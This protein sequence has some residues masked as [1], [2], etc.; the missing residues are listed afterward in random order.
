MCVRVVGA[1]LC[2]NH[3]PWTNFCLKHAG[4]N[5]SEATKGAGR[6]WL[7]SDSEPGRPAGPMADRP[8]P[9]PN[10]GAPRSLTRSLD[11]VHR[12][13]WL[14]AQLRRGRP[15]GP[16][17]GRSAP[18]GGRSPPAFA[19]VQVRVPLFASFYASV[20]FSCEMFQFLKLV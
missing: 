16:T 13:R 14:S 11:L 18:P 4:K 3:T 10:Q 9:G 12:F 6:S 7:G 5:F 19:Q 20:Q 2:A 8:H 15:A 17:L 1:H